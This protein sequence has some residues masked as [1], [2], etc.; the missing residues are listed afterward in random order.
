MAE[1]EGGGSREDTEDS[2]ENLCDSLGGSVGDIEF[3]EMVA[4]NLL[5]VDCFLRKGIF[6]FE[7]DGPAAF[8]DEE[9]GG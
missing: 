1:R 5:A 9:A 2:M 8:D 3:W 4:V 6:S 7:V